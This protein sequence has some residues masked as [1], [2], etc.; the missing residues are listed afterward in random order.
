MAR[1][2]DAS[3]SLQCD[4]CVD[5]GPAPSVPRYA[6]SAPGV[7]PAA[8]NG[9]IFPGQVEVGQLVQPPNQGPNNV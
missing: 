2:V 7:V 4:P 1:H 3:P 6:M 5:P 9:M 8:P